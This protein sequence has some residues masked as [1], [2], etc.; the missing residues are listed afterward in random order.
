MRQLTKL[1]E[2]SGLVH[3][4]SSVSDGNMSFLWG[5]ENDVLNNRKKFLERSGINTGE[6]AVMSIL[7]SDN[8]V[9]VG[10]DSVMG[11][12]KDAKIRAD[13]LITSEKNV[14]LFL[15]TGDC[16]PVMFFDTL[17]KVSALAHS[18]WKSTAAK[19]PEKVVGFMGEKY[20]TNPADLI[21]GIGPGIRKESYIL[22][23]IDRQQEYSPEWSRFIEKFSDGRFGIDI[24]GYNISRLV[25]VGVKEENIEVSPIDTAKDP[26]FFSHY[27]SRRTGEK[28][29][30]FATVIG[31][32]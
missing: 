12:E 3:G 23:A 21:V 18:G 30:R 22:D 28:E 9:P 29:G 31:M 17:H 10:A 20:N 4:F 25:G 16:L 7:D 19:L 13:A 14:F 15:L 8:I 32:K 11:I 27:R 24:V 2:I 6:C 5:E 26:D 1:R